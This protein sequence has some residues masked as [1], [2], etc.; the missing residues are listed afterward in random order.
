MRWKFL[1]IKF[2][3]DVHWWALVLL[4]RGVLINL[5][6]V[7]L[8][9]GLQQVLWIMMAETL[10]LA[11]TA[12]FLPW[13]LRI[14]NVL[15]VATSLSIIYACALNGVFVE[16][17]GGLD[18][19]LSILIVIS[20][21]LPLVVTVIALGRTLIK[22]KNGDKSIKDRSDEI[23]CACNAVTTVTAEDFMKLYQT[24]NE[25]DQWHC[26][27]FAEV[28]RGE[29]IGISSKWRATSRSSLSSVTGDAPVISPKSLE[30]KS[31]NE[32]PSTYIDLFI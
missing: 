9:N 11:L 18:D 1:F 3:P 10:Y 24:A 30:A 20:T 8:V 26:M 4:V 17:D 21:C 7:V 19:W 28:V 14:A 25:W 2:R 6:F 32:K 5:G 15:S 23:F 16:R 12:A 29:F 22:A 31:S 27:K 13:R